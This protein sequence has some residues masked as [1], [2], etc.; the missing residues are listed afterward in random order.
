MYIKL[1]I[2]RKRHGVSN[3]AMKFKLIYYLHDLFAIKI[4][5]WLI[6]DNTILNV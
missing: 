6:S 5:A 2:M 3:F 4:K 1:S